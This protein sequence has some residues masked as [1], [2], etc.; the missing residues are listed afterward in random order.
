MTNVSSSREFWYPDRNP[1][2]PRLWTV[3]PS[4]RAM[5]AHSEAEQLDSWPFMSNELEVS[6]A[7]RQLVLADP[8][9]PMFSD[10]RIPD[11]FI[12]PQFR[13]PDVLWSDL[14]SMGAYWLMS[15]RLREAMALPEAAAQF[16]PIELDYPSAA[17]AAKDYKWLSWLATEH[18]M[19]DPA[20]SNCTWTTEIRPSTGAIHRIVDSAI[21][22][23]LR[24]SFSPR[25]DLFMPLGMLS[26]LC[27][28]P[29][30]QHRVAEAGC[31]GVGFFAFG[32]APGTPYWI[33]DEDG[34]RVRDPGRE[35][36][37]LDTPAA[38][39]RERPDLAGS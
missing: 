21:S 5:H 23:S 14:L 34:E 11:D 6:E 24:E 30:L 10:R 33:S 16:F 9:F 2:L 12:R 13:V 31:V 37:S 35:T 26:T 38:V 18:D 8:D 25:F 29:A 22:L 27:A 1:P 36:F 19:V 17:I 3:A 32:V 20:L 4:F 15:R 39:L 28:A 7:Y